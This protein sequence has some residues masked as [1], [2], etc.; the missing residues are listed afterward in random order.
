MFGIL[1]S[2]LLIDGVLLVVV[3]LLQSG[4]GG[5][6]AAMG[7]GAST[8]M[9]MGSRQ[10]ASVLTKSTWVTGGIFLFLAIVLSVL[11]T[12]RQNPTP[13]LQQEFEQQ[14]QS[15]PGAPQPLVPGAGQAPAGGGGVVPGVN[16][17]E[18]QP[19]SPAEQSPQGT[20]SPS[21][22]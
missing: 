18:T 11:S 1:L 13:L 5:G 16:G 9:F 17:G 14:Q 6:L 2:F 15:A 21:G 20:G 22:G 4:K 3:V 12:R 7:G 19:G 8:D 10:A